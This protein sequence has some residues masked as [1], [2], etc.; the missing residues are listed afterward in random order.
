MPTMRMRASASNL[1]QFLES[2][3]GI[4]PLVHTVRT[5][6]TSRARSSYNTPYT[7]EKLGSPS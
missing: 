3:N 6:V 5:T 7:L 1:T 4:I 2:H